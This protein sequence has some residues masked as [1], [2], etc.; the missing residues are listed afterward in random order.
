MNSAL[1]EAVHDFRILRENP[2][3]NIKISKKKEEKKALKFFTLSQTERFLNQVKTPV[4]NAKYSHSIQYYVLF[5]LIAR[6]G[7]RIGEALSH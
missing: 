4:K 6:T 5:T 7:L 3:I 2:L 1:N